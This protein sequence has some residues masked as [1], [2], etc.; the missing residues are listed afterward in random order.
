MSTGLPRP[1]LARPAHRGRIK[2]LRG[3]VSKSS[4]AVNRLTITQLACE[5]YRSI[6]RTSMRS[7]LRGPAHQLAVPV[8]MRTVFI[9]PMAIIIKKKPICIMSTG[10]PRPGLARPAHRGRIKFLRG[11]VSKSSA[12]VNRL[13]ITQ[14]ACE[15][16]RSIARTSMRSA[17]RG[18]AHQLAVPVRMRTVFIAPMAI[19]IIAQSTSHA[20]SMRQQLRL[21]RGFAL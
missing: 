11:Y 7:A 1:G 20:P 18:P 12:A 17:L 16:Y 6:A 13:T 3:Y 9:A 19:I 8:R 2:F 10:L 4:A 14:L 21:S 15:R 5:R